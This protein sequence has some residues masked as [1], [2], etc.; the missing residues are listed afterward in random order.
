MG[1]LWRPAWLRAQAAVWAKTGPPSGL[2]KLLPLTTHVF[3]TGLQ[4]LLVTGG[5][6]MARKWV[7]SGCAIIYGAPWRRAGREQKASILAKIGLSAGVQ[8]HWPLASSS[9]HVPRTVGGFKDGYSPKIGSPKT[10]RGYSMSERRCAHRQRFGRHFAS[11]W[12]LEALFTKG[13]FL[14]GLQEPRVA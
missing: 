9:A 8:R 2:W 5:V 4:G 13:V 1:P 6:V 12:L 10:R 3:R 14:R 11:M 7:C